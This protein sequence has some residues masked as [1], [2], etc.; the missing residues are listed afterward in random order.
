MEEEKITGS[1]VNRG[2]EEKPPAALCRRGYRCDGQWDGVEYQLDKIT[3]KA[4]Y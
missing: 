4:T 1:G 2:G 3:L